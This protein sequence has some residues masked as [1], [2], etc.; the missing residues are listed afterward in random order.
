MRIEHAPIGAIMRRTGT[1]D[2]CQY[3]VEI[4]GHDVDEDE[5]L[6]VKYRRLDWPELYY[7]ED[8]VE[9]EGLSSHYY[10]HVS[11]GFDDWEVV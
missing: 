8:G 6:I 2:G 4:V 9:D 1:E 3:E 10:A 7:D 5:N 11:R